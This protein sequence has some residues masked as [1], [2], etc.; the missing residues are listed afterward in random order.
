MIRIKIEDLPKSSVDVECL[1]NDIK[2]GKVS[3]EQFEELKK[4]G[5]IYLNF[6]DDAILESKCNE[7][8]EIP[9]EFLYVDWKMNEDVDAI[10]AG[11]LSREDLENMRKDGKMSKHYMNLIL[12]IAANST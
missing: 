5:E 8:L 9:M 7:E 2:S 3:K 4:T 12:D 11:K 10:K 6:V 1:I